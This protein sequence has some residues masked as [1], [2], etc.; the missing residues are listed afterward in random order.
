[1]LA[2]EEVESDQVACNV[3]VA[4]RNRQGLGGCALVT[5]N[6]IVKAPAA[7]AAAQAARQSP[8]PDAAA[9]RPPSVLVVCS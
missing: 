1:M 6:E 8:V 3:P 2:A 5:V 4:W 9:V 7:G